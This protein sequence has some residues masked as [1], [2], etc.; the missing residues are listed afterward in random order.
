MRKGTIKIITGEVLKRGNGRIMNKK[1]KEIIT[2][3]KKQYKE[4]QYTKST[5]LWLAHRKA[6]RK[7][8]K[9]VSKM[10]AFIN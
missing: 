8:R 3:K 10:K 1:R 6:K 7:A 5:E 4:Q 9:V 2:R